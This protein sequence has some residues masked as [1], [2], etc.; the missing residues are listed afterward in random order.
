MESRK[1]HLQK[2]IIEA[3]NSNDN[4]LYVL[5]KSQ[6]AH[7]FGVD[8]LEELNNLDL[9]QANPNFTKRDNEQIEKSEDASSKHEEE[10]PLIEDNDDFDNK[11]EDI[12]KVNQKKPESKELNSV[13]S[14]ERKSYEE[15]DSANINNPNLHSAI[16]NKSIPQVQALIP[17][18]PKPKYG[19]LQKWIKR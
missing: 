2:Q 4:D 1:Y 3:L 13:K 6:W 19:Y 14:S 8:S 17:I 10:I 9:N 15:F 11:E 18:P 12:F 16:V 5:L 7:R